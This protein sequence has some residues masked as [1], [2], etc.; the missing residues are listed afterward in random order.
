MPG[1]A[2]RRIG[3]AFSA[4]LGM[5]AVAVIAGVMVAVAVTPAIAL[6]G[7]TAKNGI[8]LF[9]NLPTDLKIAPLDQKTKIY[10]KSGGKEVL[11]ASFYAQDREVIP[12]SRITTTVKNA[13]LAAEDVRFYSHGGVDP[14]G[15]IRATVADLLGKS[16]QGASTITQQYVKNVCVQEA[17]QLHTQAAVTK[18]YNVCIDPSVG[19][20]LREAR[21]AIALEKKYS[22]DQIL[23]GYLNIAPFGGR[24]YGIQSAAQ[25]YYGVDADKLSVAQAASLLAMVNNPNVLRIDEKANIAGNESRR[26]YILG[27]ELSH[28]LISQAQYDT[29]VKTPVKPNITAPKTG[30][31]AAG[32]AGYFCDYVV[33]TILGSSAFG[34]TYDDRYANLQSAGWK[35]Y[36]TLNLDLEKKA[37][38]VMNTYIP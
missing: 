14:T 11:L 26:N 34:K 33:N 2:P 31:Q 16:V 32:V 38:S 12:W 20:K 30:C 3:T 9:E 36:T 4:F 6:T 7:T 24:V 10:A 35:V 25:Y 29:A 15:I 8:G 13:T 18:A 5:I 22:K 28:K 27:N 17:E 23:L 21:L 1:S 19:R 37:Q